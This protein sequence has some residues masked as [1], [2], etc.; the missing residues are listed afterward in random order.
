MLPFLY[1]CR[2]ERSSDIRVL[3]LPSFSFEPTASLPRHSLYSNRYLLSLI[4]Y[5]TQRFYFGLYTPS[6]PVTVLLPCERGGVVLPSSFTTY[7]CLETVLPSPSTLPK[8]ERSK[9]IDIF[10]TPHR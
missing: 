8:E 3:S 4:R 5:F 6:T 9:K 1:L 2:N 7:V 10:S